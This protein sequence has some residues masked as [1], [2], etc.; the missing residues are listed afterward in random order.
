MG[1]PAVGTSQGRIRLKLVPRFY[2]AALTKAGRKNA[3]IALRRFV[4]KQFSE[5]DVEVDVETRATESKSKARAE[6]EVFLVL[7]GTDAK[8]VAGHVSQAIGVQVRFDDIDVRRVLRGYLKDVGQQGFGVF[9]DVGAFSPNKDALL[10]LR[11]LRRQLAGDEKVPAR[12][13][14]E[15]YGLGEHL[16]VEVV[17]TKVDVEAGLLEVELSEAQV[18]ALTSWVAGSNERVNACGAT[19][20]YLKRQ[21]AKTGHTVDVLR[22]ERLGVLENQLVLKP[23]T[24]APGIIAHVGRRLPGVDLYAVHPTAAWDFLGQP[25]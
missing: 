9:V 23:G 18:E 4:L 17:A 16:P 2:G 20:Q 7:S 10:S 1:A 15:A 19:R 8:V 11:T 6:E 3:S 14:L 22:V 13:I 24:S 25:S 12:K 21:V 5:L